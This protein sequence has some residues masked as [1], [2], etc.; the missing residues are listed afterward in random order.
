V[1]QRHVRTSWLDQFALRDDDTNPF[2]QACTAAQRIA[3]VGEDRV[4]LTLV[5]D[6]DVRNARHQARLL[7]DLVRWLDDEVTTHGRRADD[8]FA[9]QVDAE[10]RARVLTGALAGTVRV[11]AM[12]VDVSHT[13]LQLAERMLVV[14]RP[15]T[16]LTLMAAV[17]S[18]RSAGSTSHLT[19]MLNLPRLTDAALYDELVQGLA[20]FDV[21]VALADRLE[22]TL[23]SAVS[24]RHVVP[25]QAASPDRAAAVS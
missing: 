24:V 12:L 17:Q 5:E 13:L 2:V 7:V 18:A 16:R 21:A 23:R 22:T 1:S 4:G 25:Q 6:D 10:E 20:S 15:A 9:P 14:R 8:A 19:V 11:H 3:G